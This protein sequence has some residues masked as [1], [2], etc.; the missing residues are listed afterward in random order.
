MNKT[1]NIFLLLLFLFFSASFTHLTAQTK[2]LSFDQVYLFSE[3]RLLNQL[4]RNVVWFDDENY[5]QQKRVDGS[6]A[7]VKV[8]AKTGTEETFLKYSDYD[9][10]LLEYELT[11]DD[12]IL[13]TD[14]YKG[15]VLKKD[16]D[17]I[18]SL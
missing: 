16:N 15:F 9:D 1:L 13:K 4:P 5:L 6:T 12:N 8:N 17:F 10:V 7:I 2:K 11:L 18:F 3:P 14:D